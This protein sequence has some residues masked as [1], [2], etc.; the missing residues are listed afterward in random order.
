MIINCNNLYMKSWYVWGWGYTRWMKLT[1]CKP[2]DQSEHY[3][4]CDIQT[5]WFSIVGSI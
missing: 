4:E 3:S 1:A 5:L 2:S